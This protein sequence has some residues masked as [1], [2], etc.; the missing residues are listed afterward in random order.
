MQ[1]YL[2]LPAPAP[3]Q[4]AEARGTGSLNN[5]D[6]YNEFLDRS[7][8]FLNVWDQSTGFMR[9]RKRDGSFREGFD[10]LSTTGRA[11]SRGMPGTTAS[12][13]RMIRLS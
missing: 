10:V 12:M 9:P 4:K 6:L 5:A 2:A 11:S 1:N 7:R 13:C 8:N 3:L